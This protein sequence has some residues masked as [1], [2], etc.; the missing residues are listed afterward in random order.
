MQ[1]GQLF[2]SAGSDAAPTDAAAQAAHAEAR[3]DIPTDVAKADDA[4][5][6]DPEKTDKA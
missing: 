6:Q 4:D 1:N 3:E 5:T 2:G